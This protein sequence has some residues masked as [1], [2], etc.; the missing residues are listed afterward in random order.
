MRVTRQLLIDILDIPAE[1]AEKW[2]NPLHQACSNFDIKTPLQFA[3]FIAQV[4]HESGR[5]YYTKEI[6]GPTEWQK[7]YEGRADLGNTEPGDGFRFRGRGLIQITGR[8]NYARCG[9]A[10]GVD[11]VGSPHLLEVPNLAA[12]SAAWFWC[13]HGLNDLADAGDMRH[14]TRIING[15]YNGLAERMA[16]YEK[17]LATLNSAVD[18]GGAEDVTEHGGALI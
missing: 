2:A 14:I 3:A 6:W 5:L 4:G 12:M 9:E 16:I 7:R 8:S 15:G 10:L 13:E 11:L 18:Q 17:A 1:R